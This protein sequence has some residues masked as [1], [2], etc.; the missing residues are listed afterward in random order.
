MKLPHLDYNPWQKTPLERMY[1]V[2][3]PGWEHHDKPRIGLII[4]AA[5]DFVRH[6]RARIANEPITCRLCDRSDCWQREERA[7]VC[8]HGLVDGLGI[9]MIDSIPLDLVGRVDEAQ[10]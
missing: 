2:W 8:E 4:Y 5:H 10:E 3:L 9:R 7:Y 6:G 1:D